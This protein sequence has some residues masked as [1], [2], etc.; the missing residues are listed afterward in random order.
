MSKNRV[1]LIVAKQSF[2][3]VSDESIDHLKQIESS[4]NERI[5]EVQKQYPG[6]NMTRCALLAMLNLEEELARTKR[7]F[8][9]LEERIAA[10]RS[11]RSAAQADPGE[12]A[13]E[14]PAEDGAAPLDPGGSAAE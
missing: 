8:A 13:C 7:S 2:R 6:M 1:N 5:R 3:V 10:L 12:T 9:I 14:K 11:S 4:V